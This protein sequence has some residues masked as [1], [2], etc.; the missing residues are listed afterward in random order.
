MRLFDILSVLKT[1][2]ESPRNSSNMCIYLFIF[3]SRYT[4]YIRSLFSLARENQKVSVKS[5]TRAVPL[6]FLLQ[7]QGLIHLRI[8]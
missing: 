1:V 6:L 8:N 7:L 5:L 3:I 4:I 2:I